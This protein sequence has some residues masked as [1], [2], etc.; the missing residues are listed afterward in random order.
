VNKENEKKVA[1]LMLKFIQLG[2]PPKL[3]DLKAEIKPTANDEDV[4]KLTQIFYHC[5]IKETSRWMLPHSDANKLPLATAQARALRLII[6]GHLTMK[7]VFSPDAPYGVYTGKEL[8]TDLKKLKDKVKK[9]N[10]LYNDVMI[11]KEI[12]K[13]L[14][15]KE[16]FIVLTKKGIYQE[17]INTF[18]GRDDTDEA[19]YDSNE[20]NGFLKVLPEMNLALMVSV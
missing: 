19:E 18:G 13:D 17:L 14:S 9:I 2:E 8:G 4:E 20:E 15:E 1:N 5:L 7:D 3:Q 10:R 6:H 11:R 12:S 16:S